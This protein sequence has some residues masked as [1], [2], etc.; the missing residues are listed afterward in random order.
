M[1]GQERVLGASLGVV[2]IGSDTF[3]DWK[4]CMPLGLE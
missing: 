2:V 3:E 1:I 4:I